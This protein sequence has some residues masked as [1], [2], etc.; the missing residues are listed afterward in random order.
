MIK[1]LTSL[2]GIFI[3]F[4]FFH[5]CLNLYPGGGSM[6]VAFFFIL[7]GFGLTLGYK[8]RVISP[9]FNFKQYLTKRFVKFYPLHWICLMVALPLALLSFNISKV[10][11]LLVNAALL[12]TWI[13]IKEIYFSF[14]AVSWYLADTV[15]FAVVFPF[16]LKWIFNASPKGKVIIAVAFAVIY[17][18]VAIIIPT[19][20]HH[21]ILYIS[22]Y[23]RL[24][25]FIFGIYLAL[26]YLKLKEKPMIFYSNNLFS[27]L[28]VFALIA[29]LV[30]ESCLLPE[31]TVLFAPVYWPF[32]A[33]LILI[34]SLSEVVWG[35]QKLLQNKY[36]QRLGELS[37]TIFLVHQ[38]VLRYTTKVFSN[39]LH[40]ENAIIYIVFTLILTIVLSIVVE[41]YIL[42]PI[43]QWLT[44]KI[45]PSMT[46]RS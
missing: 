41:N 40:L 2:R 22:P 39:I 9:E 33:L 10:P 18:V 15:F 20:M 45:Q 24:T 12:Q 30:V 26:G 38:L 29:L 31:N 25:D 11:V 16:L 27:Q 4:I 23:M 32:A 14:N 36:L 42:K 19:D 5:H 21:A 6:A 13:P 46:V 28:L 44:K 34:A 1:S 17:A 37:F 7:G 8:D 3:L 35:G 43:T